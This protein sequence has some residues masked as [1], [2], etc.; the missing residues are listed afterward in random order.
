LWQEAQKTLIIKVFER[1][2]GGADGNDP[3]P[4][5]RTLSSTGYPANENKKCC[6]RSI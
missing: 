2:K 4:Q 3:A 6:L 5:D 1:L